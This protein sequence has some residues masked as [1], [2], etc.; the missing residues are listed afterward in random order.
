M[1]E[2]LARQEWVSRL[3]RQLAGA[4]GEDVAQDAWLAALR[5]PP[6]PGRPIR[7][8]LATVVRNLVRL[9]WRNGTR[10]T[11]REEAFQALGPDHVEGVDQVYERLEMQRFLAEQVM[12]LEEPLRVVV[13][14]RYVEGLDAGR[15]AALIGSPPGTVRWRLKTALDRLRQS[16]D[17]RCGGDRRV[18]TALLAPAIPAASTPTMTTGAVLMANAKLKFSLVSVL[19]VLLAAIPVTVLWRARS[20]PDSSPSAGRDRN[21]RPFVREGVA[22]QSPAPSGSPV[23]GSL[24]GLVQQ[25]GGARIEGAVVVA[26]AVPSGAAPGW[27]VAPALA[28]AQARSDGDGAFQI[29]GLPPGRYVLTA[30]KPGLGVARSQ[31]IALSAAAAV[32]GIVL[33][34][35]AAEAGLSGRVV[36]AGGGAVPGARVLAGVLDGD[37]PVAFAAVAD[38][39]GRFALQLP[40]GDYRFQAE[41]DGYAPARFSVYLHLPMV[42][43]FRLHP[44]SRIAGRV[45]ARAGGPPLPGAEVSLVNLQSLER[46]MVTRTTLADDAGAFAFSGMDPSSYRLIAHAGPFVGQ[47]PSPV[48][49]G[50]A[51]EVSVDVVIDRGRTVRGMA[52]ARDGTPLS[53]V[54]VMVPFGP[55]EFLASRQ[56]GQRARTDGNGRFALE[57]LPPGPGI[58]ILAISPRGRARQS[59]DLTAGDREGV[60]LVLSEAG[61]TGTVLDGQRRPVEKARLRAATGAPPGAWSAISYSDERGRFHIDGLSVGPLTVSAIHERGFAEVSGGLLEE[62]AR[63]DVEVILTGGASVSGTVRRQDGRVAAG[64]QVFA[65]AGGWG[66]SPWQ[67]PT[68]A[69]RTDV[70]GGYRIDSVPPGEVLLRA[71]SVGDDPFAGLGSRQARSDRVPL[72]LRA[73]QAK[74]G[75]D[76]V[77]LKNDLRISGRV[78]DGEGR[79]VGGAALNA[80][81]DADGASVSQSRTLSQGDGQFVI[82]GLSEGPHAIVV[83]DPDYP[84]VRRENV[85]AGA[86]GVEVRLQRS[87]TLAGVVLGP[88]QRPAPTYVVVA[89]PMLGANPTEKDL[90]AG[91]FGPAL[92]LGVLSQPNGA[93]TFDSVPAATYEIV[94]YLPDRSVATLPPV[95]VASGERKTG[96][97]L[98]TQPSA[99]IRGRVID[100]RTGLPIAGARAEGRGAARNSLAATADTAGWFSLDGLPAG[101]VA[102]FA[103]TAP[104]G[105]YLTDCQHRLLPAKGGTLEIGDVPLFPGPAQKLTIAG[106]TATGLWFHSQEGRPTVYAVV[107]GSSAAA[108]G[109]RNGEFVLAVDDV[110]VRKLSSSVVEGLVATGGRAVKLTVQSSGPPRI[111]NVPRIGPSVP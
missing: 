12:A 19:F 94:A 73:G 32:R 25:I 61:I 2:L 60:L 39:Q 30:N 59:L 109:A 4:E 74:A 58:E 87:G 100:Y 11:R 1:D 65:F 63:K 108:A 6:E 50:L 53:D 26:T 110:D 107:P 75:V 10:R 90:R 40:P 43:D 69:A 18:W 95:A 36:D 86:S 13:V 16:L 37:T 28:P 54:A 70:N 99:T 64:A 103:I 21:A 42:R 3:A 27:N 51:Q 34:V 97:R 68:A 101:K 80:L 15:I 83:A 106:Q 55:V 7:P 98:A 96:L 93:F 14:L 57:G 38:E 82:E 72:L 111:L 22:G 20:G 48:V 78:I 85:A 84:E 35:A 102:D 45:L 5:S 105:D 52:Q 31:P 62:G 71:V 41:A 23:A 66:Q 8:W 44:A 91:W 79:A 49:V 24:A 89:R 9:R 33:T 17:T 29:A 77:V 81:P 56:P 76:L 67:Q 47:H 46:G 88:G 92:R 104:R